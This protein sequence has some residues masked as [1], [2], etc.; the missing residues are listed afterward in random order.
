[1]KLALILF[2]SLSLLLGCSDEKE[3]KD[4]GFNKRQ[5]NYTTP[6]KKLT[7]NEYP[8]FQDDINFEWFETALERQLVRFSQKEKSNDSR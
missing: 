4:E 3:N 2:A 5:S 8:N 7:L 6:T 1:M